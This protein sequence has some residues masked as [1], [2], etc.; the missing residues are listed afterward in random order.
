MLSK[1]ER[2]RIRHNVDVRGQRTGLRE[3]RKLLDDIDEL[4]ALL[5]DL[6]GSVGGVCEYDGIVFHGAKE[7]WEK[8]RKVLDD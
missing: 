2:E 1:K 7:A 5:D 3:S 6:D 8:T 4:R